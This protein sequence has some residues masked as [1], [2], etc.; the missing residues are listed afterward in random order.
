MLTLYG[1]LTTLPPFLRF[2]YCTALFSVS[3]RWKKR[4]ALRLLALAA[5]LTAALLGIALLRDCCD[6]APVRMLCR[7]LNYV[8]ALPGLFFLFEEPPSTLL[9]CW[10]GGTATEEGVVHL[11]YFLQMLFGQNSMETCALHSGTPNWFDWFFYIAFQLGGGF[12][13]WR[14]FGHSTVSRQDSTAVRST[15]VLSTYSAFSLSSLCSI[16]REYQSESVILY[17]IVLLFILQF[18]VLTLILRSGILLNN[19]Y[20]EQLSTMEQM[21]HEQEK[22]YEISRDSIE[23]IN[24]TCHDLKHQLS[25]MKDRLTEQEVASIQRTLSLYDAALRTG[26]ETLDVVLYEQRLSCQREGIQLSCMADGKC[27]GFLSM[28]HLY[29]LFSNALGNAVEA[30][31]KLSDP[32]QRVIDIT[33]QQKDQAVDICISNYYA[34]SMQIGANGLPVT[35]KENPS[36]HGFGLRSMRYVAGLYGGTM[37]INTEGQIFSLEFHIPIP[38]E[39]PAKT[40]A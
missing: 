5:A 40:G 8:I 20:R 10:C 26:C 39:T 33:V 30:V 29:A 18:S 1:F 23:Y 9:L 16:I 31:R 35:S 28:A 27:L 11:Y 32:E 24:T 34:G 13:V 36:L 37:S 12:L 38:A 7:T 4:P 21:V 15:V 25:Q 19:Q 22:Q 17:G 3:L 14:F 6:V 2:L